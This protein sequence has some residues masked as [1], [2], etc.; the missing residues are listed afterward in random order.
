MCIK[1]TRL[2]PETSGYL[3]IGHDEAALLNQYFAQKYIGCLTN[4]FGDTNPSK[5]KEEFLPDLDTLGVKGDVVTYTSDCFPQ[6]MERCEEL[7]KE[8]KTYVDDT[9]GP[10]QMQR[11]RKAL[12]QSK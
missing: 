3:H 5:E 1:C 12:I 7:I 11:E 10:E 6:L 8:G 2:P 9:A 4:R